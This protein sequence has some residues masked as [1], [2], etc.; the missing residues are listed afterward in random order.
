MANLG[1]DDSKKLSA[2][3]REALAP[4]IRARAVQVEVRVIDVPEL[5]ARMQSATLNEI[6]VDAFGEL[7][8]RIAPRDAYVDACDVDTARFGRLVAARI[9]PPPPASLAA[10]TSRRAQNALAVHPDGAMCTL[11][12]EHGADGKW[13]VVAAASIIAKVER[14]R[15][16][17]EL[18]SEFGDVGSGYAS[19]PVTQNFLKTWHAEHGVLPACARKHW[20]TSRRLVPANRTLGDFS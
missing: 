4:Q 13:A 10:A 5:D 7:L 8:R 17:A 11:R 9:G 6:E 1:V 3:R 16:V 19:D 18:Q 2:A 14:D 12:S 15:L 20:E